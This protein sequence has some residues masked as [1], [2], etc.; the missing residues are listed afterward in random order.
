MPIELREPQTAE[1]LEK[2]FDLRWR[3]LRKPWGG[4]KATSRDAAE[5]TA[6]HLTAWEYGRLVGAGRFHF[7]SPEEAQIRGVAVE[8]GHEHKGIGSTLMKGLEE[9]AARAGARR[10]T[11]HARETALPFYRKHHYQVLERSYTLY[12]SIAHWRMQ[13]DL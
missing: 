4:E 5:K 6:I 9:R 11:L 7:L 2:Y 13:K 12:D 1:E 3:I 8:S 10:I